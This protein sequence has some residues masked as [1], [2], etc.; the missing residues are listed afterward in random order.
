MHIPDWHVSVW[1]H[2]LP[3]LHVWPSALGGLVHTPDGAVHTPASW[4]WSS[5]VHTFGSPPVQ[6]PAWHVSVCVQAFPSLQTEPLTFAGFEQTPDAGLHTPASWHWSEAVH[7]TDVVPAQA[8]DWHVSLLVQALLS[9]HDVPSALGDPE[10]T[11]VWHVPAWV[12]VF[13]PPHAVP[14]AFGGFEHTPVAASQTP[15]LWH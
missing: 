8:P 11:P 15:A 5:G 10:H 12:Q 2:A 3:S 4:H 9:L 1:V 6:A 14:F 7:T 13:A